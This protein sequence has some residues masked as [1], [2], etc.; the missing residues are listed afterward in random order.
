MNWKLPALSVMSGLLLALPWLGA[1]GLFLLPAL[2]PLFYINSYFVERKIAYVPLV[3]WGHAFLA[4]LVW[5]LTST[6]WIGYATLAG[7]IF[8]V[9]TNSL[10]MS[11]VWL[12]MHYASRYKKEGFAGLIFIFAWLSFEKMHFHWELAWP[13]LTLGNGFANNVKLIQWYEFTGV[14][15]GSLWVLLSNYL[16]WNLLK[17]WRLKKSVFSPLQVLI[18]AS[19]LVLP[20]VFSLHWYKKYNE[21]SDPLNVVLLQPNIDPYTDKFDGMPIWQQHNKLIALAQHYSNK[22]VDL[23]VAPETALHNIWQNR[24]YDKDIV[25][26]I[27]NFLDRNHPEAAFISGAMTY[28]LYENE[29]KASPTARY[30]ENG[31]EM[32]DAF[33]SALFFNSK[34]EIA[35]YHKSML[36]SGVEKMPFKR[37]LRFIDKFVVDLGGT[38]G[39]L[40]T[41][42]EAV[43]FEHNNTII[44]VPICYESVFGAHN[45]QFVLKGAEMLAVIT[46]DG[47]WRNSPG[48]RQHLSFSRIQAIQFRRSVVRSANTGI[49]A[50]INQKGD[51]EEQTPWWIETSVYG[52]VNRNSK[53]T[54]Y[55]RQ[56]DYI[57]R[58]SIFMFVLMLLALLVGAVK[59]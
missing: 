40:A 1:S 48:Y 13:W 14:L 25:N 52:K 30:F 8:A 41:Q 27:W 44:G 51:V 9:L 15:G 50:F 53:L 11:M 47:W 57:A 32:Y 28:R 33:N 38:T 23:F 19:F 55:A 31:T 37:Y 36:V 6:W 20:M 4:M 22:H 5:N 45:R 42:N 16:M 34:R 43:V 24:F 12:L 10:L 29:S 26:K 58:G 49:S 18:V 2:I 56:G 17:K 3:F 39:T 7:A 35:F 59:K 54:F 46:N 21:V